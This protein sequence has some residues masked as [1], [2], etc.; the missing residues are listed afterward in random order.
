MLRLLSFIASSSRGFC[1]L[2]AVLAGVL[3]G[4]SKAAIIAILNTL[5]HA[6]SLASV[7]GWF[8]PFVALCLITPL[9]Q[10]IS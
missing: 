1:C 2:L 6:A 7:R 5:L 10:F 4:L 8:L 9:T 3:S